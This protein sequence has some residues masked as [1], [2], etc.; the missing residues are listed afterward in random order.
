MMRRPRDARRALLLGERQEGVRGVL[1]RNGVLVV[2]L[3]SHIFFFPWCGV[4]CPLHCLVSA[5]KQMEQ[6]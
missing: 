5:C 2:I 1:V 3:F 6:R 4:L